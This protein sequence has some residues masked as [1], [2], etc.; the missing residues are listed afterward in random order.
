M[1][2]C[3]RHKVPANLET[4]LGVRRCRKD[5]ESDQSCKQEQRDSQSCGGNADNETPN[6]HARHE[7]DYLRQGYTIRVNLEQ[8]VDL[9]GVL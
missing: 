8:S 2:L 3:Q 5:S 7:S 1:N 4:I 6:K 9:S